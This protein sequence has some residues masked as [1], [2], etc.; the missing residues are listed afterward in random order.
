[1]SF[2]VVANIAED[3]AFDQAVQSDPPFDYVVHTASPYQ[4]TFD[5]PVKDCLDPAIRG[6]IGLLESVL[7]HAPGV[8]RVVFTSSSAAILNPPN[9][10]EVYDESS[11][12]EVTWEQ[13]MDPKHVYRA[14]K[15]SLSV[16]VGV[17]A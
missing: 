6:T 16:T 2:V 9:H 5:N 13:A 11:W 3:N 4:Y 1:M 14:S 15:A 10:R 17:S 7:K 12:S 8:K